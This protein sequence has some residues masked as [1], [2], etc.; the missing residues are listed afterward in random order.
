[1]IRKPVVYKRK[2]KGI[3]SL[4]FFSAILFLGV[5]SVSFAFWWF[6][7]NNTYVRSP[8]A[9]LVSGKSTYS[10]TNKIQSLCEAS[11]INCTHIVIQTDNTVQVTI[12]TDEQVI[13]SLQKDLASQFTSLQLTIGHLTIEGKRF[14]RLDFRFDRPVIEY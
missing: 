6:L 13:F 4:L 1:M 9:K 11:H 12:D 14:H 5:V 10:L 2:L 3:L 7:K 8:L